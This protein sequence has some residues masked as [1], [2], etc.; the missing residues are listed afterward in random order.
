MFSDCPSVRPSDPCAVKAALI[1]S[2]LG[3]VVHLDLKMIIIQWSKGHCDLTKHVLS[4]HTRILTTLR[5][6]YQDK[7][8]GMR[9]PMQ[10]VN[11]IVTS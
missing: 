8:M 7:T 2:L 10:K 9:F 5:Y 4:H 3:T 11:F 1:R 6:D